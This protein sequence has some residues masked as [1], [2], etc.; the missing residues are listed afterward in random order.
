MYH[1]IESWLVSRHVQEIF[2]SS[3]ASKEALGLT[4]P[5]VQCTQVTLSPRVQLTTYTTP[6]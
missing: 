6:D 2:V 3:K 4:R 1:E 5:P